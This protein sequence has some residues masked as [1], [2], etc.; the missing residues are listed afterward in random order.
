MLRALGRVGEVPFRSAL[1]DPNN[2]DAPEAFLASVEGAYRWLIL[3]LLRGHDKAEEG[4]K[5]ELRTAEEEMKKK[6]EKEGRRARRRL[7]KCLAYLRDRVGVPR[8]MSL[9]EARELRGHLNWMIGVIEA[10]E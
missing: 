4:L 5:A 3:A 8:D 6:G 10:V 1:A 2:T 7:V 9:P